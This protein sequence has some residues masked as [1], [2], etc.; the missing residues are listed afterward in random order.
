M[1]HGHGLTLVLVLA[2]AGAAAGAGPCEEGRGQTGL[3]TS[4]APGGE[5]AVGTIE[6]ES[7]AAASGVAVGDTIVQVNGAL[8]HG[9]ADYARAVRD[10]RSGR[11]ALLLLV[12]RGGVDVP[13][14]VG[15]SAW[16]RVVAS[17]SPA[18]AAEAPSVRRLVAAAPP[19]LPPETSVTVDEVTHGLAALA[20]DRPSARLETFRA[21]LLQV[22][23]QV[24]TLAAR[25]AVP[26]DV[27]DG[28]RTVLGYHDAA[29]VAWASEETQREREGRPRHVASRDTATAPYFEDSDVAAAIDQFPFL[30]DTVA[31]EPSRGVVGGE[32]AGLWRPRQARG[33]LREHGREELA[34]LTAWLASAGR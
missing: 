20:A 9:C 17:T 10:A 23:R 34:R 7:A 21:D 19:P 16:Q 2:L 5:L 1:A 4:V 3:G 12:R 8:P 18:P 14:V 22:H 24:E 31:R 27:V 32:A 15:A 6:V 29:V 33:L 30:R 13:L 11:K 28:L 26:A 25:G